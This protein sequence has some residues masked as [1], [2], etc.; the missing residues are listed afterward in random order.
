M[1][2]VLKTGEIKNILKGHTSRV[3]ALQL[4]SNWKQLIS[5]STDNTIRV[6]NLDKGES[7]VVYKVAG[8]VNSLRT[9]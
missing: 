7:E 5:G 1:E 8:A 4:S 2:W 9:S 6:W 3:S